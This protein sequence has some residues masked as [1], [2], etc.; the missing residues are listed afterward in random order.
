VQFIVTKHSETLEL[1]EED[2]TEGPRVLLQVCCSVFQHVAV[3]RYWQEGEHSDC[4]GGRHCT[5]LQCFAV[6]GM[7]QC[8]STF[9]SVSPLVARRAR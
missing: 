3:C 7:L 5:M 8:V 9:C 4:V 1:V 6:A 2:V